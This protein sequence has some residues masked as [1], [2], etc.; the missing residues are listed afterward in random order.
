M[1]ITIIILAFLLSQFQGADAQRVTVSWDA[2]TESDLNGYYVH[3]GLFSV[4]PGGRSISYHMR[5]NAIGFTKTEREINLPGPG[6][7]Y[8]AVTAFDN[9]GNVSDYS[10]EVS[11]TIQPLANEESWPNNKNIKL[12]FIYSLLDTMGNPINP[13]IE[14]EWKNGLDRN[15]SALVQRLDDDSTPSDYWVRGDTLEINMDRLVTFNMSLVNKWAFRVRLENNNYRTNWYESNKI[16]QLFVGDALPPTGT[17]G[18]PVEP[19]DG[20]IFIRW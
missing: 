17:P 19:K 8:F 2:N 4:F 1:K 7:W 14:M 6:K 3:Y 18:I 5:T 11:L 13:N 9:A 10:E 16:I 12:V 20:L 15:W